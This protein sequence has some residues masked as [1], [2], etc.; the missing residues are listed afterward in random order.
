MNEKTI[1]LNIPIDIE[2]HKEL[3]RAAV[4]SDLRM[5]DYVRQAI[6]E[7]IKHDK[8]NDEWQAIK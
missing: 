4:E 2:L 7:K 6:A 1:R 3:R 5:S 8:G